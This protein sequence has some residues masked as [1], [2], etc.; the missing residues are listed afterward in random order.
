MEKIVIK[1]ELRSVIGKQVKALRRQGILPGVIYGHTVTPMSISLDLHD[2]SLALAG[3]TSSSI[4][5]IDVEGKQYPVLVREKQKNYVKNSLIHVD[6]Q[7]VSLTEK[8]RTAVAIELHGVA[9]AIK[10]F[11]GIVVHNLSQLEVEALPQD[12]P[13]RIV[14]DLTKLAHLGDAVHVR[15]LVISDKVDILTDGDESIVVVTAAGEEEEIS[16]DG[17]PSEPEVIERGKKEEE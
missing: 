16:T 13:E 11:N 4:I 15:D 17:L 5:T 6:F 7:A 8:I 2:A 3:L 14:V 12:L 10:D 1:A 9:P